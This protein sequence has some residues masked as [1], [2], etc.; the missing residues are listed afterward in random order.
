MMGSSEFLEQRV[1]PS[2]DFLFLT[3]SNT[4]IV[5]E[6]NNNNDGFLKIQNKNMI[7]IERIYILVEKIIF[8]LMER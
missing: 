8:M 7:I 5:S 2:M 3:Q 6:Q 1:C 4:L